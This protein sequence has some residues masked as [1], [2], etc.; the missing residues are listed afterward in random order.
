MA[1]AAEVLEQTHTTLAGYT[2]FFETSEAMAVAVPEMAEDRSA[3]LRA[4]RFIV[5]ATT[6]MGAIETEAAETMRPIESLYD[7]IQKAAEGNPEALK[8]VETNVRTDVI[9]R[10]IKTGHV[11]KV[12]LNANEAGKILQ[13]GQTMESVQANSLR[14][15]ANSWQ[16]RER[17]EAETLNSFRFEQLYNRGNLQDN[18][19]V[20]FSRAADNMTNAQMQEAGFFTETMSC[21]IQV[22]TAEGDDLTT[23]SAFVSGV[24]EPGQ[25]RHDAETVVALA[26]R[27]GVDLRGKS[28][29]EVLATPLLIPNQLIPNGVIDI[30]KMFDECA[31]GTFFGE[32]RLVQDYAAYRAECDEREEMLQPKIEAIVQELVS[33]AEQIHGRIEATQRLHK[34]SEKHMVQQAIFDESIDVRVFGEAA[35]HILQARHLFE[36]GQ[37]EQGLQAVTEAIRTARS[38]SCPSGLLGGSTVAEMGSDTTA[39]GSNEPCSFVSKKCPEC[40][41]KNVLTTVTATHISG[42]CGCV[43]RK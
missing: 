39:N 14:F 16:M 26:A 10:T 24:R 30:V 15:A 7:G 13:H 33:E 40:G 20:V 41:K 23:E 42:K 28:A 21:A 8:M 2:P 31:G 43:K 1:V 36:Q 35:P 22:T 34:L 32:N 29:A 11:I 25:E 12:P 27:L 17:T 9:E 37:Y 19:F 38:S 18:S 3:C 5:R 6:E 4:A